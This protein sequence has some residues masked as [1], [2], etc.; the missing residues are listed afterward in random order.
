MRTSSYALRKTAKP[1]TT[2]S[3]NRKLALVVRRLIDERGRYTG[4]EIDI[5]SSALCDVLVQI[6]EGVESLDLSRREPKA[7][8]EVMFYSYPG[9]VKRYAEELAKEPQDESLIADI[10]AAIQVIE[11][12]QSR[13]LQEFAK[14]TSQG[15]ISYDLLWALFRPNILVFNYHSMTEQDRVLLVRWVGY[16]RRQDG[17]EYL[18]IACDMVH[19]DGNSFGFTREYLVVDDYRGVRPITD[20]ASYP[21]EYHVD[22]AG[23][24]ARAVEL[25]KRFAR[26]QPHS[27]GEIRGHAMRDR[28]TEAEPMPEKFYTSGRVMISPSAF[29]RFEPNS[30]YNPSVHRPLLRESLT[31]EEYVICTPILLGF[32]FDRK[33]W[34][35]FAMSRL[36]EVTWNDNAF[37]ALVLGDKQ[38]ALIHGL[39]RQHGSAS[40]SGFDDI[41]QGKGRGLVGLLSGTPG[42]GKTLTA[43]AVAE[44]T[45]KPL[46][47]VS[48]GELGTTPERVEFQLLRVLELA[49]MWDAVLLLDEAEVFLQQR[50]VTDI[51]RNALVSI[52]LRQL[53]YYQGIMILTTNMAEQFDRAFESRIHFSVAY[54]ELGPAA[55]RNIW[56]TFFVQASLDVSDEELDTL[57][58]HRINGR[59]I[60]NAF[61]SA[62][63]ISLANGSPRL[64]IEDVNVVLDVLSDWHQATRNPDPAEAS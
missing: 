49:Q 15:E 45:H 64:T 41:I 11:E 27:Y 28:H 9:L 20:L 14:L 48:A 18:K 2:G 4:T 35:A 26:M 13:N 51:T 38:K 32:A 1:K 36:H 5:K 56:N 33:S 43:E 42:C 61:S 57:A 22:R 52:F 25:G 39:V 46:Y 21:L 10:S 44:T 12:D 24:H 19:N 50:S 63:T 29:R 60:K 7:S 17:S 8:P 58:K 37:R 34:G 16:R 31:D 3:K 62:K 54:P 59:Q 55:R 47:A 6:N 40:G 53:E 30:T 23:V